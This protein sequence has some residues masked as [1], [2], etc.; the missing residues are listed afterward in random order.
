MACG[1]E[2]RRLLQGERESVQI[3]GELFGRASFLGIGVLAVASFEEKRGCVRDGPLLQLDGV[4]DAQV[5]EILG[6]RSHQDMP[7]LGIGQERF[8][9]IRVVGLSK[10]RS[11]EG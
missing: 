2:G 11:Q 1:D 3:A 4:D 9:R 5:L 7:V 6:P 10:I 8:E